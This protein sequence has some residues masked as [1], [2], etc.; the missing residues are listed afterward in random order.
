MG[1]FFAEYGL[2][3]LKVLTIVAAIVVVI[4]VAASAGRRASLESLEIEHLNK[5]YRTLADSLR[6]A[7]SSKGERK[8]AAKVSTWWRPNAAISNER[9]DAGSETVTR[10]SSH[11]SIVYGVPSLLPISARSRRKPSIT[12]RMNAFSLNV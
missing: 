9:P 10:P 2:F 3:F 7:I 8:K 12:V 11:C 4:V 6:S 1:Q 5:K